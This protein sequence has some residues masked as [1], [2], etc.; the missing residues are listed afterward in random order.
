M[1]HKIEVTNITF[2]RL[3]SYFPNE[4]DMNHRIV[5]LF[6]VALDEKKTLKSIPLAH[7]DSL[8][9]TKVNA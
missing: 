1:S 4:K 3:L 2:N 5:K 6:K 9:K 7:R 8:Y